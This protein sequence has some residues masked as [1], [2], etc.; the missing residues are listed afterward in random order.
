MIKGGG[1]GNQGMDSE[2]I[3]RKGRGWE[4]YEMLIII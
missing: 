3:S 4:Q 1:G 2:V